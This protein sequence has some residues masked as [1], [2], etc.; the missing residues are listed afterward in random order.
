MYY[1]PFMYFQIN[2]KFPEFQE[3]LSQWRIYF[4]DKPP[5]GFE[6][7]FRP[8]EGAKN[9]KSDK[10][11]DELKEPAENGKKA[12]AGAS[13]S[14]ARPKTVPPPKSSQDPWSSLLGGGGGSRGGSGKTGGSSG[15]GGEGGDKMM[16]FAFIGTIAL[17]GT[18]AY[19]EISYREITWK[20]FVTQ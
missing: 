12:S 8:K 10:K 13:A 11:V 9:G 1:T 18:I 19:Y 5:K 16:L 4:T 15:I 3:I 14:A 7:F 2:K 20:D 6:K 17:I